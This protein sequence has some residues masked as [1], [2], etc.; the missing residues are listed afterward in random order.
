MNEST[1]FAV[2]YVLFEFVIC[3]LRPGVRRIRMLPIDTPEIVNQ[4]TAA[5]N[6]NT[7]VP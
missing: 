5:D 2:A 4:I 6:K 1:V 3:F 7:F